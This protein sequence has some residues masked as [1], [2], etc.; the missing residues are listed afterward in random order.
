MD[1]FVHFLPP[2]FTSCGTQGMKGLIWTTLSSQEVS[3][4]RENRSHWERSFPGGT[5]CTAS[6]GLAPAS[7]RQH[8]FCALHAPAPEIFSGRQWGCSLIGHRAVPSTKTSLDG[9]LAQHR[10]ASQVL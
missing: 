1:A 3:P 5:L 9:P 4:W 6:S 7:Q 10:S 2:G 8:Y